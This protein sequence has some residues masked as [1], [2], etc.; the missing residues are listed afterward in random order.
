MSPEAKSPAL[1]FGKERRLTRPGEFL[2]VKTEGS[3]QRGSL[4]VL[5]L[6]AVPES[7]AFR[8]GFVTSK[9]IGGA[10]VRNRVRRRLREIVRQHQHEICPGFWIVSIARP[11][12]ARATYRALADEWLRL[13]K[14]AFIIA[15]SCS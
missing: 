13:A 10:V 8:A 15:P 4:L 1:T 14:R 11:P 6:L 3:A 9:R 2:R 5:G 7:T 12:A